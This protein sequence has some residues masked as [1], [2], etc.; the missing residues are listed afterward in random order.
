[1]FM[2]R[3]LPRTVAFVAALLLVGAAAAPAH[4]GLFV[5]TMASPVNSSDGP[6]QAEADITTG[7]GTI[8]VVLKNLITNEVSIGQA[9]SGIQFT[10]SPSPTGPVTLASVSGTGVFINNGVTSPATYGVDGRTDA[11][12]VAHDS[13]PLDVNVFSGGQPDWLIAGV[14]PYPNANSSMEVHSPLFAQSATF[15][16]NAPGV[17]PDSIITSPVTIN[18]GTA[19]GEHTVNI[20][21]GG[22]GILTPLPPS[23]L[24]LGL[25]ALGLL[26]GR[27]PRRKT[28]A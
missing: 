11:W 1:M 16:L 18:F 5:F 26:G 24:M 17:T 25:G 21:G 8:T 9:I 28:A 3:F 10:V 4:A 19:P 6:I 27:F 23:A 20:P 14:P 12:F 13:N 7:N 15:V 2:G 22:G